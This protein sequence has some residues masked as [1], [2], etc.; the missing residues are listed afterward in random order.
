MS[1]STANTRNEMNPSSRIGKTAAWPLPLLSVLLAAAFVLARPAS[2][3]GAQNRG[4]ISVN[5]GFVDPSVDAGQPAEYHIEITNGTPD[6]PPPAPQVAGLT[7]TYA[8]RNQSHQFALDNFQMRR[9]DI[10]IFI[11]SVETTRAGRFVVP[12]Q[13]IEVEGTS[14]RTPPS[15]L[16]V[17]GTGEAGT[18]APGQ[19]ISAELI[20]P[21]TTAYV[22]ELIPMEMRVYLGWQVKFSVELDPVVNGEGFSVLKFPRPR[23][24]AQVVEGAQVHTIEYKTAITGVKTGTLTV[25]PVEI[26]PVVQLPRPRR[27]GGNGMFDDPLFGNMFDMGPQKRIKISTDKATVEI[28][29]LP[30]GK[31]ANFSGGIGD[32]KLEAEADPRKAQAGDPVTVRLVLSGTGNFDRV[33]APLLHDDKG[34]RTYPATAK[35]RADDE[36]GLSGLKTFEQVVVADGPRNSLPSYHLDY[37]DPSTG[38]YVSLDTPPIPVEIVGG[39]TP[40]PT[41]SGAPVAQ[42]AAAVT[43]AATPTPAP[44][45][46]PAEDI[47]Y[48]RTDPGAP[49]SAADFLPPYR[50]RAFWQAQGGIGAGLLALAAV[51]GILARFRN[52]Q[53]RRRAQILRQQAELQRSLHREDT[54]RAEFYSAATQ[55]VRLQAAAGQHAGSLSVADICRA[56]GLDAQ[57]AGAVEE[58]F[59][60]HDELAYSGGRAA[61]EPVPADE[62]RGVLAT[63]ETLEKN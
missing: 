31:P 23:V 33:A 35:F 40:A 16:T 48:I 49:G 2:A 46:K 56:R 6:Q 9:V 10:A 43:P 28:K 61:R 8:G 42:A 4:S 26:Q 19:Q 20:V 44:P 14:L 45:A 60:R 52:D 22:G 39:N 11:Y 54:G 47:L 57:A 41:A 32:F 29:P 25:G 53:A 7:F 34:L 62:R 1:I 13:Q 51:A 63:L 30:P 18:E 17:L 50:R 12:G 38:K 3:P 27:R 15:A 21:K 59:H 5:A 55:L 24:D 58:M 37:L 36:V